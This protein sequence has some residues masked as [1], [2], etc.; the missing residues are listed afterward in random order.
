MI[1]PCQKALVLVR[2]SQKGKATD[3]GF[4]L[5]KLE[6]YGVENVLTLGASQPSE[7]FIISTTCNVAN[8]TQYKLDPPARQGV[9]HVLAIITAQVHESTFVAESVMLLTAD[10]MQKA[11][12]AMSRLLELAAEMYRTSSK[13]VAS[14]TADVSPAMMKKCKV[15]G[16]SPTDA[17]L[18]EYASKPSV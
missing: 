10:E 5:L 17:P 15:L 16:K 13:R 6:I 8:V 9:T 12:I 2:S 11:K 14:W 1:T 4:G 18:P 7:G 3:C